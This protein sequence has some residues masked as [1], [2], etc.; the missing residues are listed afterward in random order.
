MQN[1]FSFSRLWLLIKKQWF[2]NA[3]LYLLS[4]MALVGILIITFTIWWLVN[5][6]DHYFNENSTYAIFFV[7]LF[8]AGLIFSSTTFNMLGDKPK[9]IYWLSVPATPLEKLGTGFFYSFIVFP[10]VYITSFWLIKHFTFFM[11][12]LNPANVIERTRPDNVFIKQVAP[13]LFYCFFALQALFMLGSVYFERAA[14]IK[15][16]LIIFFIGL[17]FVLYTQFIA[18]NFF[19]QNFGFRGAETFRVYENDQPPRIYQLPGW[20]V[21]VL[22]PLTKFIWAPVLL[23]ATY[24]RLKEKEI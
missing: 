10:T 17:L 9:G 19:P 22:M 16:I 21:T 23:A 14:F 24:F 18:H 8:I 12:E 7:T 2:D 11:V 13:N 5:K 6:Q 4:V 15:T 1:T 20:F 3:R